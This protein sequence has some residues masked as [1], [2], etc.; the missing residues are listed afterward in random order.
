[1]MSREGSALRAIGRLHSLPHG[2]W[3]SSVLPTTKTG[4]TASA[5]TNTSAMA[6][7]RAILFDQAK[8]TSANGMSRSGMPT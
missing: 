1:M 8:T 4:P 5:I 7:S 2:R 6:S 3:T